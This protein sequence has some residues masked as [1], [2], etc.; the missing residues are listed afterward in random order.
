MGPASAAKD[1]F[2]YAY[3]SER[4]VSHYVYDDS[5]NSCKVCYTISGIVRKSNESV[6]TTWF[7]K[8]VALVIDPYQK[9][10]ITAT[11]LED[12]VREFSS[13]CNADCVSPMDAGVD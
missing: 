7:V 1:C 3:T 13:S 6:N 4:T 9:R 10:C 11:D 2:A 5:N 12:L 8:D